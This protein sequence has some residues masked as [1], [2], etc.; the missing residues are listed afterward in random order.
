[1]EFS[2]LNFENS[3]SIYG[4]PSMLHLENKKTKIRNSNEL[5]F[6]L[7]F[8]FIRDR[9]GIAYGLPSKLRFENKKTK[10]RNSN[11]LDFI[12]VFLFIRDREGIR[13]PNPQNRNLIFYPVELRSHYFN[14]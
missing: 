1:M 2:T 11:E 3:R 10:I 5:D 12:L 9:E 14:T 13:T 8:L 6:I 4:I 7:V